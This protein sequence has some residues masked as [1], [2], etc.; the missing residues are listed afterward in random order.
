[1]DEAAGIP[2]LLRTTTV[3]GIF[4]VLLVREILNWKMSKNG[5]SGTGSWR[6]CKY[7]GMEYFKGTLAQ[8]EEIYKSGIKTQII[9]ENLTGSLKELSK[10]ISVQTQILERIEHKLVP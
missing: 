7:P 3:S 4:V 8:I 6:N 5:N 2:E 1:M 10:N 9:D